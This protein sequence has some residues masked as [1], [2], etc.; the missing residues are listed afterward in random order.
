MV[1]TD[2]KPTIAMRQVDLTR[3]LE[4]ANYDVQAERIAWAKRNI[5][6]QD[7][8]TRAVALHLLAKEK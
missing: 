8:G 2:G 5:G 7:A 6:S 4:D 3:I 1:Y